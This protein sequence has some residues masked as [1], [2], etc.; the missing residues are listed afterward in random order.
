MLLPVHQI[1]GIPVTCTTCCLQVPTLKRAESSCHSVKILLYTVLFSHVVL[2]V[3]NTEGKLRTSKTK[4]LKKCLREE[5]AERRDPKT[6]D[7][8]FLWNK[9][10]Q[11]NREL[12]MGRQAQRLQ[13]LA[14][15]V[16]CLLPRPNPHSSIIIIHIHAACWW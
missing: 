5:D 12:D 14:R 13:C 3:L 16:T 10:N 2:R 11:R 9:P 8:L 15:Y 7:R 4:K 6:R 1:I